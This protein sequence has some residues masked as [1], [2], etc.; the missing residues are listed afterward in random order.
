MG[1]GL[2]LPC[3]NLS[4]ETH[5]IKLVVSYDGTDFRGWAAQSGQRTVQSTLKEAIH[6]FSGENIEIFGASRTDSGAHAKGQVVHFDCNA[7]IPIGKWEEALN[8][9]LPLDLRVVNAEEMS[10][11]FNARFCCESRTY[12]YK[13]T[14]VMSDPFLSRVAYIYPK[15]LDLDSMQNGAALLVGE[16]DFL[17]FTEELDPTVENTRR[18]LF[19]L[20]VNQLPNCLVIE[21]TGNAFLRG[22]MRRIS[23]TLFEIG[24]GFRPYQDISI[25]ISDRRDNMQWAEVLPARGLTLVKVT[26]SDPPI[27]CRTKKINKASHPIAI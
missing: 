18:T 16:H 26:Y 1:T 14:H 25:L 23:G 27:D 3:S 19:S 12:E 8:R 7:S 21:A 24:R 5:R 9:F 6:R 22:M 4:T 20:E 13:I 17:A 15:R 10:S 11:D 2:R